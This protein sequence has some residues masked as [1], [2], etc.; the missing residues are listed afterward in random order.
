MW[1]YITVILFLSCCFN[2]YAQNREI[3]FKAIGWEK[4]LKMA[5]KQKQVIFM[6]C[7]TSWC[8][9]CKILA[10]EVFTQDS[11]AD[12]FNRNFVC[13]KMDME[14][15]GKPLMEKYGV[16][17]FPTLLFIEPQSGKVLHRLVGAGKADWL[18]AGGKLALDSRNNLSGLT[19]RYNQGERQPEFMETYLDALADAGL[20]HLR[21]SIMEVWFKALP[22]EELLTPVCWKVIDRHLDARSDPQSYCFQ[23]LVKLYR[24]FY[25]VID[26]DKVDFRIGVVVQNYMARYIRWEAA[27][28]K[29]FD[30]KG[31]HELVACLQNFNYP[32]VASWLAQLYTADY[33]A[34]QDYRGMIATMKEAMKYRFMDNFQEGYY[35]LLFLPRLKECTDRQLVDE[36]VDWLSDWL[37]KHPDNE[38]LTHLKDLLA[39]VK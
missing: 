2:G 39:A 32:P 34:K 17:A 29:P 28:G 12:F 20:S 18:M 6:D 14:K 9:P 21:D 8:G 1:K 16:R 27:N 4:A 19:T 30:E 7:Y 24:Q 15:E 10:K 25:Q 11:V 33:M 35:L 5:E 23:R 22:D 26:R 38:L 36:V 13:V 37:K 3:D 31:Y